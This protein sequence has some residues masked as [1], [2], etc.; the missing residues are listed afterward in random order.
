MYE[1]VKI[2]GKVFRTEK[3]ADDFAQ[4]PKEETL[5]QG[6]ID[7]LVD[8]VRHCGMEMNVENVKVIRISRKAFSVQIMVD[9][10]QL[11]DME[12]LNSVCSLVKS[13]A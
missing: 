11:E 4:L 5:Q 1:G 6:L 10:K 3:Y 12:Y 13:D 8:V 9:T 2:G 7:R